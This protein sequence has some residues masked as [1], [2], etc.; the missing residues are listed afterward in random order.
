MWFLSGARLIQSHL[1]EED[2]VYSISAAAA[3]A[4]TGATN[5]FTHVVPPGTVVSITEHHLLHEW[6]NPR[7]FLSAGGR[8]MG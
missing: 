5:V 8:E 3:S 1:I 6:L 7:K 2:P 4:R